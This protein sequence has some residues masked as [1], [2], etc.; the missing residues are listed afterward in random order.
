MLTR[1]RSLWR[2]LLR[3]RDFEDEM[4][5]EVRFH[6]EQ[7]TDDL[8]RSGLTVEEATRRARIELGSVDNVK[9]DCREASGLRVLDEL[10]HDVRYAVRRL[11]KSPGFTATA[12]ATLGLCLGATLAIFAVVDSVL[13]RPLPFPEPDRLVRVFNTYPKAGVLDDGASVANYYERQGRIAAFAAIA[14]YRDGTAIVGDT[15]ATR[16]EHVARVTP[17][18]FATLG[19]GPVM[20]RSFTEEETTPRRDRVAVLTDAAWRQWFDCDPGVIGRTVRVDGLDTTVVGVLPPELSF[21]SSKARI[22]LPLSSRPEDRTM[23]RRHSGS[24]SQMVARL[25]PRATLAEAQS[26]LDAHNAAVAADDPEAKMMAVAGFRSVVVP[27][28]ADHVASIRPTLLLLQAGVLFLLLIGSVNVANLLLIRATARTKELAVRQALG[29]S[30]RHVVTEVMAETILLTAM[31]GLLGLGVGAG[32]IQLLGA[33]GADHLPLGARITV[34]ARVALAAVGGAIALGLAL[35]VPIAWYHLR[36]HSQAALHAEPRGATASRAAQHLRHGF[37][38][39]QMALAFVLL[40]GA[41]LL[42]LSLEKVLSVSPGFRPENV[43]SGH[44][45][46]PAASY[47]DEASLLRFV[48]RLTRDLRGQPGVVAAG[49][50]TNLPL[51]GNTIKSAVTAQGHVLQ[52]GESLRGHYSYGVAGD[53]FAALGVPLREGRFLDGDDSRGGPRVCVVDEDF[54]RRYW[55]RGGAIGQRVFQGS[56]PAPDA[57][58]FRVVGVVGAVRQAALAEDEAQGAVY[59]PLA[60]RLDRGLFVVTRASAPAEAAGRTLAA[61]VR[62]IDP[63]LPVDDVRSMEGRITDSLVARRSPALLAGL[64]S[65]LAVLLTALGTYGVLSYAVAQRR[66]EIA[67]RMALG[68][69]PEQVRAQFLSLALRLLAAGVGIGVLGAWSAGRA[70]QAL[71]FQVPALH[72]TILASTAAILAVV[73]LSACLLPSRR[74]AQISPMEALAE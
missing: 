11:R 50:I 35:G 51:S 17:D 53:Y 73:S 42:G 40:A 37:L 74:A 58:A 5:Q 24:N 2:T 57:E 12:L 14:V 31:G 13:L 27:L 9:A 47:P 25:A 64:F 23:M 66:R 26:Q 29:A 59:F 6:L 10:H 15:G 68:A 52:P 32:G 49:V 28:H 36:G 41:G 46:L 8:V 7:H 72:A 71:L 22:Y 34:D 69:R 55:P 44:V 63:E 18:F 65:S 38:V 39:V 61:V 43:S 19:R 60:H 30:A 1:L 48:E 16:R 3:R 4:A 21:L 70:M 54:A 62:G 33:L 56:E 20:G 67:L 45:S